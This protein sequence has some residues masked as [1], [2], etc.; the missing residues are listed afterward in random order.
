MADVSDIANPS[1]LPAETPK[2]VDN[3]SGDTKLLQNDA[4]VA[5]VANVA[6]AAGA[7]PTKAEYD[8]AV[9]AINSLKTA[10]VTAGIMKA[11]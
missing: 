5:F 10:L 11:S 1:N 2:V 4:R 7:N 8:V 6:V 9:A 3:G